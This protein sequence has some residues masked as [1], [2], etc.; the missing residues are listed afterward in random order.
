MAASGVSWLAFIDFTLDHMEYLNM[1]KEN[2]K[3]SAQ[4]LTFG[5]EFW[6]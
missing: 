1:L 6:L 2:F 5:Y 3:Q 4:D